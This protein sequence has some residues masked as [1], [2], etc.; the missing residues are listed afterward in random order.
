[1]PEPLKHTNERPA[2]KPVDPETEFRE[3]ERQSRESMLKRTAS[4]REV[5]RKS[6][7]LYHK[8]KTEAD[9]AVIRDE[10]V[11]VQK[12]ASEHLDRWKKSPLHR[13]DEGL[14][15][16][17][18]LQ[19]KL[20]PK[21][22]A[23]MGTAMPQSPEAQKLLAQTIDSMQT[24]DLIG[25]DYIIEERADGL[26]PRSAGEMLT[27]LQAQVPF[28]VVAETPAARSEFER[29]YPTWKNF[30]MSKAQT[31]FAPNGDYQMLL[32]AAAKFK[33]DQQL[34]SLGEFC[35]QQVTRYEAGCKTKENGGL[36]EFKAE[37]S[38]MTSVEDSLE[39]ISFAMDEFRQYIAGKPE[40]R[41]FIDA[42]RIKRTK[43]A[44]PTVADR[45]LQTTPVLSSAELRL[46]NISRMKER[47]D[48]GTFD[49]WKNDWVN[50]ENPQSRVSVIRNRFKQLKTRLTYAPDSQLLKQSEARARM[51]MQEFA[52]R[53]V[54]DDDQKLPAAMV[55]AERIVAELDQIFNEC[56]WLLTEQARGI[57]EDARRDALRTTK[58]QAEAKIAAE[59]KENI[60][61]GRLSLKNGESISLYDAQ[62]RF[63]GQYFM[64][65]NGQM[66]NGTAIYLG[67]NAAYGWAKWN[68]S[69][70]E[71]DVPSS[72]TA[73][74]GSETT[75]N[76]PQ[77]TPPVRA[78]EPP[79]TTPAVPTPKTIET[80]RPTPQT[81]PAQSSETV[82]P[83]RKPAQMPP[84]QE[85]VRQAVEKVDTN[86]DVPTGSTVSYRPNGSNVEY[87][88]F[89]SGPSANLPL[90][91][92]GSVT[93]DFARQVWRVNIAPSF[94]GSV[95]MQ[96][97]NMSR[98]IQPTS[99]ASPSSRPS[100]KDVPPPPETPDDLRKDI[101]RN[102]NSG[103][104]L[105][106]YTGTDARI[107][108]EQAKFRAARD[109][110][111]S[112]AKSADT[113]TLWQILSEASSA[114]SAYKLLSTGDRWKIEKLDEKTEFER[115]LSRY[116]E[117]IAKDGAQFNGSP[118]WQSFDHEFK[119][120]E[121]ELARHLGEFP[122]SA[123]ASIWKRAYG[124]K[125][126]TVLG[127]R[128]PQSLTPEI[129]S[130][131]DQMNALIERYQKEFKTGTPV[132]REKI[133]D[134]LPVVD[135][136]VAIKELNACKET[137]E[138]KGGEPL[139]RFEKID[140]AYNAVYVA[141]RTKDPSFAKLVLACWLDAAKK[142]SAADATMTQMQAFPD[143]L[144]LLA[145]NKTDNIA[146]RR[147]V[148]AE[149]QKQPFVMDANPELLEGLLRLIAVEK[150]VAGKDGIVG[151]GDDDYE[152]LADNE[153]LFN[154]FKK[155]MFAKSEAGLAP[156]EQ[157]TGRKLETGV[158]REYSAKSNRWIL[159]AFNSPTGLRGLPDDVV[160]FVDKH[161]DNRTAPATKITEQKKQ[162]TKQ[163]QPKKEAG[164]FSKGLSFLTKSADK[165]KA[166]LKPIDA[167]QT[168]EVDLG[169][170]AKGIER[171]KPKP[172]NEGISIDAKTRQIRIP[173]NDEFTVTYD[174]NPL[175][176]PAM[177][178]NADTPDVF[179]SG[180]N[181]KRDGE[182][183]FIQIKKGYENAVTV[184]RDSDGFALKVDIIQPEPVAEPTPAAVEKTIEGS[185]IEVT[186]ADAFTKEILKSDIPVIVDLY[187]SWCGPCKQ[188]APFLEKIAKTDAGRVKVVKLDADIHP[189]IVSAEIG[190][191][192]YPTLVV[193]KGGKMLGKY[194]GYT[195][196]K[197]IR[198]L[199][200]QNE[201]NNR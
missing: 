65:Y 72:L 60:S 120:L 198:A 76:A 7:G 93:F 188:M 35:A 19:E 11:S 135:E 97:G 85:P 47:V 182:A 71:Y 147:Y 178:L 17:I 38:A 20:M 112:L 137:I 2:D 90:G 105:D 185:V 25:E 68:G 169:E 43:G 3:A 142:Y 162:E 18:R 28:V 45:I 122:D 99:Y 101:E 27:H 77:S 63:L 201:T 54:T 113:Q 133:A 165:S 146:V 70:W 5:L 197:G 23:A 128:T 194:V 114:V 92:A 121:V 118:D 172:S 26:P 192:A 196:E 141:N 106:G 195:D 183:W 61:K 52:A 36:G 34:R 149:A 154:T 180:L 161:A 15:T 88:V 174:P 157:T 167:Q 94:D 123:P 74:T 111:T 8:V 96:Y 12:R 190:L 39:W 177:K 109:R 153:D 53:C 81:S 24:I 82:V 116:N 40:L 108:A 50:K 107:L 158:P 119:Q 103:K 126:N 130:I 49:K 66:A 152:I 69:T 14:A 22:E 42:Q 171:E 9:R 46:I 79:K 140:A 31:L 84:S 58:A 200:P 143:V 95:R 4:E 78:P 98:E 175:N 32:D 89:V 144:G 129:R 151:T 21:Y 115:V 186:T 57:E 191:R 131:I 100:F 124:F 91:P 181:V 6:I 55:D 199:I 168:V 179:G 160:L 10:I 64:Q 127:R 145:V 51:L 189:N 75:V 48:G 148:L 33:K 134:I 163:E 125:M 150:R 173:A 1:M 73:K 104:D 164:L 132:N 110:F 16:L 170:P 56:D 37:A 176:I 155:Y 187:A 13:T 138:A 86:N 59:A 30:M 44:D 184:T 80:P 83:Q 67:P 102:L 139:E 87:R 166:D 117:T 41:T 62:N 29:G 136:A 193:Y 159:A 156:V